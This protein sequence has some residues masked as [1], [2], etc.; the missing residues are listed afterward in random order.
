MSD[1][2]DLQPVLSRI[3]VKGK[4]VEKIGSI[5]VPESAQSMKATE[6]TVLAVG[7]DVESIKEGDTI[8]FG[9]YSGAEIE[10]NGEKYVVM[11]DEDVIAFVI[12]K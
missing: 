11:N 5:I 3:I 1:K 2:L 9:K 12:R 10:R 4:E 8:F 7:E 6:G